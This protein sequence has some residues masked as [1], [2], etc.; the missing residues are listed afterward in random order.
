MKNG[1]IIMAL[2]FVISSLLGLM[3]GNIAISVLVRALATAIF[4][5]TLYFILHGLVQKFLPELMQNPTENNNNEH[6]VAQT[7]DTPQ[8]PASEMST[9][10]D[11]N[12]LPRLGQQINIT[13]NRDDSIQSH[14]PASAVDEKKEIFLR[15]D[16]ETLVK[17]IRTSLHKED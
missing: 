5:T 12:D 14:R 3:S 2:A 10:Q 11:F 15:E 16:T 13:V 7:D 9:V 6:V 1:L 4:S 8:Q 17:M